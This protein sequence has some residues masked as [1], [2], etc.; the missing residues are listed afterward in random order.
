MDN[1]NSEKLDFFKAIFLCQNMEDK[2]ICE[3]ANRCHHVSYGK[4]NVIFFEKDEG[5]KLFMI[6]EGHVKITQ[7][8]SDG[9]EVILAIFGPGDFF[10]E[11][12]MIDEELRS[13]NAIA[14]SEVKLYYLD[15]NDFIYMIGHNS[16][17]SLNLMKALA[18]RLRISDDSIKGLFLGDA[19]QRIILTIYNL[20]NQMGIKK[21]KRVT[22][23]NLPTQTDL[24][25]L[26]GTSRETLSRTL[27]KLETD[28][29]IER[30]EKDIIILDYHFFLKEFIHDEE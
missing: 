19:R 20:A 6:E 9:N 14:L 27:K 10:G 17:F 3:L 8:N 16:H 12:S 7:V 30:V 11:M 28:K 18:S 25:N 5:N 26:S 13:A 2:E 24:A 22:I 29:V 23:S 21:G 1:I 4:K 15:L